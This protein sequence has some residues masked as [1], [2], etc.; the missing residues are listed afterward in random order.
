MVDDGGT[1]GFADLTLAKVASVAGSRPRASTS[2][3]GRSPTC[4]GPWRGSPWMT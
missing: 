3:S 1:Q 2:T 4:A